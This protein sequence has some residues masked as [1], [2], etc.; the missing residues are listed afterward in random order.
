MLT[1]T[2]SSRFVVIFI[3]SL[4]VLSVAGISA[5]SD[6]TGEPD[7]GAPEA[8]LQASRPA[9]T[10][11]TRRTLVGEDGR[12]RQLSTQQ[13]FQRADGIFKLIHSD[14]KADGTPARVQTIFGY[15][16]LGVFR[17][18]Q[19]R[20]RLVF[21]GPQ[22]EEAPDNVEQYLRAH[23]L[24]GGA[25]SVQGVSAIVWRNGAPGAAEYSEELRAPALGGLMIKRVTVSARGRETVEPV[26]IET[27]E[28]AQNHF[29]ELFSYPVDYS[30]FERR[31]AESESRN[32]LE[33]AGFMRER[34]ARMRERRP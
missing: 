12:E 11:M 25:E 10:L 31:V 20:Q 23:P 29:V 32:K 5:L 17:L 14:Y 27:G 2:I 13:R 19:S 28:P 24:F 1:R 34:L 6:S 4:M 33:V 18:D 9:F 8:A 7:T 21:V 3:A 30:D 16:G 22:Q 26:T 15:L